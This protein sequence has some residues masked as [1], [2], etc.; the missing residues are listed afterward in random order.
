MRVLKVLVDAALENSDWSAGNRQLA[1]HISAQVPDDDLRTA[2]EEAL[3]LIMPLLKNKAN[4]RL[5]IM[6]EGGEDIRPPAV[7]GTDGRAYASFRGYFFGEKRAR[8]LEQRFQ[9]ANGIV[10]FRDATVAD[11]MAEYR[12]LRKSG[13]TIMARAELFRQV[14][15][16][17][18]TAAVQNAGE[19]PVETQEAYADRLRELYE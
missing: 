17:I 19:L 14:A 12:R 10:S 3:L 13:N 6:P 9:G 4:K 2:L 1:E 8:F 18:T 15:A 7:H 11:I 5:A 16:D